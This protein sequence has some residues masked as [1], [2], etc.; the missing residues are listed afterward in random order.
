MRHGIRD[1]ALDLL[2]GLDRL[3]HGLKALLDECG[4]GWPLWIFAVID[5]RTDPGAITS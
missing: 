4:H 2:L 3:S 1:N 5:D